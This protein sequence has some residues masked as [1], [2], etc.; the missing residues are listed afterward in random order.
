MDKSCEATLRPFGR[1][2]LEIQRASQE[3]R[4]LPPVGDQFLLLSDATAI[5]ALTPYFSTIFSSLMLNE[6]LAWFAIAL[7]CLAFI[8]SV[9]RLSAVGHDCMDMIAWTVRTH[10]QISPTRSRPASPS[11]PVPAAMDYWSRSCAAGDGRYGTLGHNGAVISFL[12][13]LFLG[14][15]FFPESARCNADSARCWSW[16]ARSAA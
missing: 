5:S 2:V 6:H 14:E 10:R 1:N 11:S 15:F 13:D 7:T 3:A 12:I 8:R 16:A 9:I 4:K